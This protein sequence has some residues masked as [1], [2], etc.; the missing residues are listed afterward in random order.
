MSLLELYSMLTN[1]GVDAGF[2][3]LFYKLP[4]DAMESGL[5]PIISDSQ[6]LEMCC[7]LDT[8]R[9]FESLL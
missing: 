6:V 2:A 4:K 8:S 3:D 9:M 1:C 5:F 7:Y